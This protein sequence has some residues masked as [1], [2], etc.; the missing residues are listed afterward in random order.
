[1]D[2]H[3]IVELRVIA[4]ALGSHG[5]FKGAFHAAQPG[6][7]RVVATSRFCVDF[8][9]AEACVHFPGAF[10]EAKVVVC[11]AWGPFW[12]GGLRGGGRGQ[13]CVG[14]G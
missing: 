2:A 4:T 8:E 11:F 13:G 14:G 7:L 9:A 12:A 1:M 6:H 5:A 3:G 10:A